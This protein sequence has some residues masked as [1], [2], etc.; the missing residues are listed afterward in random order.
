MNTP[1]RPL[2]WTVLSAFVLGFSPLGLHSALAQSRARPMAP[3]PP[4]RVAPAPPP[5]RAPSPPTPPLR[6]RPPQITPP[7][8]PSTNSHDNVLRGTTVI[9]PAPTTAFDRFNRTLEGYS[10]RNQLS[11]TSTATVYVLP[12]YDTYFPGGL[13]FYPFYSTYGAYGLTV[14]SLYG[15]YYDL[16]P[17]YLD[18]YGVTIQPP[19]A[20][21]V[22]PT[23]EADRSTE[24]SQSNKNS[25]VNHYYLG[26]GG[27]VYSANDPKL[28]INLRNAIGDI[29]NAWQ[30]SDLDLLARH[31]RRNER[32]AVFLNGKYSYSLD[33]SDYLSMTQ[34]AFRA[35]KT[36][37]FQLEQVQQRAP[38][39]YLVSGT[40]IYKDRQGEEHTV[41]VSFVLQQQGHQYYI[42]QVGVAPATT[43]N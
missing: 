37:R 33:A 1:N 25:D 10:Y 15:T 42:I 39:I 19:S 9:N 6:V 17:P 8:L 32:V 11:R 13:A 34:D 24:E 31:L 35:S 29:E 43:Q 36:V 5:M 23:N 38:H 41:A 3:A 4:P 21:Y 26:K 2:F 22:P 30:K 12:W 7:S 40:H 18:L 14:P 16:C 28:D 27:P 20:Y